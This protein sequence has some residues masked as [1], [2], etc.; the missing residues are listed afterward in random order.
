MLSRPSSAATQKVVIK[1]FKVRPNLPETFVADTLAR[2]ARAVA[3]MHGG[4]GI[5]D[6]LEELYKACER[7]CVQGQGAAV[8]QLL[9]T[10][11]AA[12]LDRVF[13]ALQHT[14]RHANDTEVINAVH[15]VWSAHCRAQLMIRS[16]FLYLD[17]TH[18]I[19]TPNCKSIWEMGL[20][21]FRSR[22]VTDG[23]IDETQSDSFVLKNRIVDAVLNTIEQERLGQQIQT[24][25]MKSIMQMFLDLGVYMQLFEP[26]F[27]SAS[28]SFYILESTRAMDSI[29]AGT[30]NSGGSSVASYL[31]HV[32]RRFE[33]E[34]TRC[35][36]PTAIGGY[37]SIGTRKGML[38]LLERLLIE[39]CQRTL[40][41]KGFD[42]LIQES[43]TDA[44][45]RMYS[46]FSKTSTGLP[47]MQKFF[48]DYISKV[49]LSI[50][51]DIA[52]DT[53]MVA[54]LLSLKRKMDEMGSGPFAGDKAFARTIRDSFEKF[55]NKRQNK[56][57][58]L[59]AKHID[60]LMK[61]GKGTSESETE[62]VLDQC[63]ALFRFIQGK[64]VFEA[65]YKKDLAKRL[66]LGKSSSV[67]SEKSM[68][69]KLKAECGPG[70]TSKLESMFKD[71]ETSKDIVASFKQSPRFYERLGSIDMYV[72]FLTAG[73]WPTYPPAP[74]TIPQELEKCQEAYKEFYLSKH[75]GRRLV[76]QN[77]L[78]HCVLRG[79][80]KKV[81]YILLEHVR[82]FTNFAQATKE[83]SVSLFQAIILLMFNTGDVFTYKEIALSTSM[84]AKELER[85]LQSLACGKI[86]ILNK[87][88]KGRDVNPDD[89]FQFNA[90]F[91]NPLYRIKVNSIQ[92][93]ETVEENKDTT[94]KVFS[95]RQYQVDAAIVRIMKT[96]KKLTHTLLIAE[97][98]DQL[99]FPIKAQDLKKRIE[100]LIDREYLE[101]EGSDS[102]TYVYLA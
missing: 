43:M 69:L 20:D 72:N 38:I 46:L 31:E 45:A 75:S 97:L 80:F 33:E 28:E 35:A 95:D 24:T 8:Y 11:T 34:K 17:R 16:V 42:E 99:K 87:I 67:D 101:R 22:L 9:Q 56:P 89:K 7:L 52:R 85:T 60:A 65:F 30:E 1:G 6:S 94:E 36:G 10:D 47:E 25:V 91:E 92:M 70:F 19:Q 49:G 14:C 82:K 54:D 96:R 74:L 51:N 21:L 93:K 44:L 84:E 23:G 55:I 83:L 66:L 5:S 62:D 2:L 79:H 41:E 12:H 4:E 59:I 71:I 102:S 68:L 40:L 48:G 76:W 81:F 26:K 18:V 58:E 57:A 63:L 86:R 98:F 29:S 77:Q 90:S 39:R 37:L 78:G 88:P 27:L 64:D 53:T 50:V 61:A 32:D 15:G 100:S 13:P 73:M 3:S